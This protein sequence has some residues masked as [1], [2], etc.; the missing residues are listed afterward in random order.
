MPALCC[1]Y[2][3]SMLLFLGCCC[4]FQACQGIIILKTWSG[5][6]SQGN[7]VVI[8]ARTNS[9][10]SNCLWEK[11]RDSYDTDTNENGIE[12][13][14]EEDDTLCKLVIDEADDDDHSGKWEVGISR[15]L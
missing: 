15:V 9:E 10:M 14:M 8:A 13:T 11:G 7:K 2:V 4:L 6:A 3:Q 1:L 12:V 5:V